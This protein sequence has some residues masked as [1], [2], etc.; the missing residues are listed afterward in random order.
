MRSYLPPPE[1]HI[2]VPGIDVISN[3]RQAGGQDGYWVEE[4]AV[5]NI[6][7]DIP[8]WV[9]GVHLVYEQS[10]GMKL[11]DPLFRVSSQ[12]GTLWS[13]DTRVVDVF[14]DY[15]AARNAEVRVRTDLTSLGEV[16]GSRMVSIQVVQLQP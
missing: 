3:G 2:P 12:K 16:L 1:A 4:R 5:A 13:R 9:Q 15:E 14:I 7:S 8:T 6:G 11:D 10:S